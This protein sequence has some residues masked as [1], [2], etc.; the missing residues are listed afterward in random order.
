M[1]EKLK[2]AKSFIVRAKPREELDLPETSH[3]RRTT[4]INTENLFGPRHGTLR[5]QDNQVQSTSHHKQEKTLNKTRNA[6]VTRYSAK[7]EIHPEV[8]D[9]E[10]RLKGLTVQ[11][12]RDT[13]DRKHVPE[14]HNYKPP[15]TG[16][17]LSRSKSARETR[18]Q[19]LKKYENKFNK[20]DEM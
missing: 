5:N 7:T 4:P 9:L 13:I 20:H 17:K 1:F 10:E 6:D 18:T 19:F 11:Q 14:V 3:L 8:K 16:R 12:L 15:A 2:R